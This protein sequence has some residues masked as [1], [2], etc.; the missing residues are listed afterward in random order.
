MTAGIVSGAQTQKLV[1]DERKLFF[2]KQRSH[3][4]ALRL[5][6]KFYSINLRSI[7]GNGFPRFVIPQ[8]AF[9]PMSC[10]AYE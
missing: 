4:F 2:E 7:I 9:F 3:F 8:A 6:I 10:L 1:P 5:S